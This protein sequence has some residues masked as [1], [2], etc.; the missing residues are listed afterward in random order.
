MTPEA[1]LRRAG[2]RLRGARILRR[3][4]VGPVKSSWLLARGAERFVLR[5]DEPLAAR[6][7]PDRQA[8][9]T[10]WR[11]AAA[12]GLAPEPVLLRPGPPA[13][14]VTRYAPGQAWAGADLAVPGRLEALA[15]LLRRLHEARL[16]GR[17][18]D[19]ERRLRAY[20][21]CIDTPQARRLLQSA[22]PL[23]EQTG[24]G[25]ATLCHNDP[26]PANVIGLRRPV[27]I[28]WEYAARGDP[29]FDLAVVA[30]HHV[31]PEAAVARFAA[32]Y[33][34]GLLQVPWH[35]LRASRALYDHV[36]CL[37]LMAFGTK[38]RLD[39]GQAAQLRSAEYRINKGLPGIIPG[40]SR[41]RPQATDC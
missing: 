33:F 13:V 7:V 26:I 39:A 37:W 10:A 19:L 28:D 23:M 41:R 11:A 40:I 14:L 15:G 35:R 25:P 30:Q 27:L 1:A 8:E 12:A 24:Q 29:L 18:L 21:R 4:H 34:G 3:L 2:T 17:R 31:L 16:P 5:I 20:A 9:F 32:A 22:G 6:F 36:L 38:V